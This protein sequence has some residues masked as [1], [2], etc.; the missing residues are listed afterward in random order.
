MSLDAISGVCLFF[1]VLGIMM[2]V[3]HDPGKPN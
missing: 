3:A 1:L 2:W